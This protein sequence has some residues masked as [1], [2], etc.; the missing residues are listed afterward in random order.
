MAERADDH[1]VDHART[2]SSVPG[3]YRHF[4]DELLRLKLV[5]REQRDYLAQGLRYAA[6]KGELAERVIVPPSSTHLVPDDA[7]E[8]RALKSGLVREEGRQRYRVLAGPETVHWGYLWGAAEPVLRVKPGASVTI[9][10]VSHEGLLA[11]QGPPEIFFERYGIARAACS[12]MP[13]RS[14]PRCSTAAWGRT[15]SRRRSTSRAPSPATCW[16]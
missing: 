13:P 7:L 4:I 16:W 6:A 3:S 11:D 10:T 2:L 15:S 1:P 8:R 9:D 14:T 12:P 5:D